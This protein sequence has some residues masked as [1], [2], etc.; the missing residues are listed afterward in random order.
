MSGEIYHADIK[1]KALLALDMFARY[2]HLTRSEALSRLCWLAGVY[3][4]RQADGYKLAFVKNEK[5]VF[6]EI[7][8]VDDEKQTRIY[9][10]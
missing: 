2:C 1:S 3:A 4:Q 6:V 7:Q 10:R 5:V 9:N 8:R